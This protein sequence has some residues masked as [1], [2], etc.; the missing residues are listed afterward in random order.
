MWKPY[1][2]IL[3]H[4]ADF[5]VKYRFYS[6]EE[7]G[8][9]KPVFQGLRTD[10]FYDLKDSKEGVFSAIF[11]EFEDEH[12][13]IILND[14][15]P[16]P[17]EGTAKMWIIFSQMRREVHVNNIKIGL[18]GYFMD[19]P[20]KVAIAEIIEILGLHSNAEFIK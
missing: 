1:Q 16:V 9:K 18:I 20:K 10:F 7:G 17:T 5:R 2:E 12:G 13:N 8:R 19:G 15:R 14:A 4:E 11:P 3:N 6:H